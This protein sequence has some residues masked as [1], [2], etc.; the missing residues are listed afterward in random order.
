MKELPKVP[1][2]NYILVR[3]HPELHKILF[4]QSESNDRTLTKQLEVILKKALL[5]GK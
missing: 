4:Q 2:K 3:L 1:G 5:N